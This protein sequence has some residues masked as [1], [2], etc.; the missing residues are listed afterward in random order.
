MQNRQKS[1]VLVIRGQENYED[2]EKSGP[3]VISVSIEG[4]L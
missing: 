2:F 3:L 4:S 1:S